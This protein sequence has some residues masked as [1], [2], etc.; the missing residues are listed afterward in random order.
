MARPEG[1]E[2]PAYRFEACRSIQLSYGRVGQLPAS[3]SRRQP[4]WYHRL[5]VD[6]SR[7]TLS[8]IRRNLRSKPLPICPSWTQTRTQCSP[9]RSRSR[10]RRPCRD[11]QAR[12][13]AILNEFRPWFLRRGA[14][15]DG[16]GGG[17]LFRCTPCCVSRARCVMWKRRCGPH[18]ALASMISG[19]LDRRAEQDQKIFFKRVAHV[20]R[21]LV[22]IVQRFDSRT[23]C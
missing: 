12:W 18:Y 23:L 10:K 19:R 16:T 8:L 14:R 15:R 11:M 22:E 7:S 1:I 13:L 6:R 5:R 2:P 21:V 3:R 20:K 17:T 4:K 9:E